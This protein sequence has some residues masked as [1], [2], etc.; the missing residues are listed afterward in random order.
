MK[1]NTRYFEWFNV[2]MLLITLLITDGFV[3]SVYAYVYAY[4]DEKIILTTVSGD[5]SSSFYINNI[6][7]VSGD[8][9]IPLPV[10]ANLIG[11]ITLPGEVV[12]FASA[13]GFFG[14]NENGENRNVLA[15]AYLVRS[16]EDD[17]DPDVDTFDIY[18]TLINDKGNLFQ[19]TDRSVKLN[20][21][22]NVWNPYDH[23]LHEDQSYLSLVANDWN[24]DGYSDYILSYPTLE[25]E[26]NSAEV[27]SL[28]IDGETLAKANNDLIPTKSIIGEKTSIYTSSPLPQIPFIGAVVD[29]VDNDDE[30]EF[31]IYYL[32]GE[33]CRLDIY[34]RET[35]KNPYDDAINI[36]DGLV[37]L[38]RV[39]VEV[40][41]DNDST[42]AFGITTGDFDYDGK[43]EI[44]LL[45][46]RGSEA[47]VSIIFIK[48][49]EEEEYKETY[50]PF[51]PYEKVLENK[52]PLIEKY[53]KPRRK[54]EVSA[55]NI[56]DDGEDELVWGFPILRSDPSYE[57][58][59]NYLIVHDW[60]DSDF[61]TEEHELEDFFDAPISTIK[62]KTDI[63]DGD[64]GDV[65]LTAFGG[66]GIKDSDN[67]KIT[68]ILLRDPKDTKYPEYK[69]E[70][71]ELFFSPYGGESPKGK[72][73]SLS[74]FE[75]GL[76]G[77]DNPDPDNP[78][79]DDPDPDDPD[80]PKPDDYN[81]SGGGGCDTGVAVLAGAM[82]IFG[83]SCVV[84]RHKKKHG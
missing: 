42:S 71:Q 6:F 24:G 68:E 55:L 67:M 66:A 83:V 45:H 28:Y 44:A 49:F 62:I 2:G 9:G 51:P 72:L 1:K 43:N 70:V 39:H 53:N 25:K 33:G 63:D 5:K 23:Y 38:R 19:R 61:T 4:E 77:S 35:L 54:L 41:G 18:F 80:P 52:Y 16:N 75:L 60:P 22:V 11:K 30:K 31:I 34:N 20:A 3:H 47:K 59:K 13:K 64:D 79:P 46:F 78:D 81:S 57:I 37:A 50:I 21:S 26:K 58:G 65:F 69:Y 36:A 17:N 40:V 12:N 27:I 74:V 10:S 15:N 48:F 56:D 14:E 82:V 8:M 73:V 84:C 29:N 76:G 7:S 32:S